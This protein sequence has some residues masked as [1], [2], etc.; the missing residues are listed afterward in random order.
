MEDKTDY[1]FYDLLSPKEIVDEL[2][3]SINN[4]YSDE[5]KNGTFKIPDNVPKETKDKIYRLALL[6]DIL[7][8][9]MDNKEDEISE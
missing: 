8:T 2:Q 9:K 6:I 4:L 3:K 7:Q 5:Y 1:T